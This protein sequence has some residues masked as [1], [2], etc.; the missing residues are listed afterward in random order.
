MMTEVGYIISHDR[1][2]GLHNFQVQ[3]NSE[4]W[5][6]CWLFEV[7]SMRNAH[8]KTVR[9]LWK[10]YACIHV[11]KKSSHLLSVQQGCSLD[12]EQ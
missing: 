11:L 10:E 4:K 1:I 5:R 9:N 3:S 8:L 12:E 2:L 7:G 6:Y